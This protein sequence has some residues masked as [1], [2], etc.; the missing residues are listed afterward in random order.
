MDIVTGINLSGLPS[1]E[2]IKGSIL[3]AQSNP[4]NLITDSGRWTVE[5]YM[6]LFCYIAIFAICFILSMGSYSKTD[7]TPYGHRVLYAISAGLWNIMYL[8]YY[9]FLKV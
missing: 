6:Y 2:T 1:A 5:T 8:F 7:P 9:I 4:F 3:K